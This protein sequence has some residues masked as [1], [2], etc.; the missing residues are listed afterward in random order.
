MDDADCTAFLQWA[1]PR[2]DLQWA[3][4]RRVREQVCKRLKRRIHLLGLS[5]FTAYQDL[6]NT[7]PD[8]WRT[9][10]DCCRITISRFFRD[11]RVFEILCDRILPGIAQRA[12][13][14]QRDAQCWSAGCASGEE[15]YTLRLLWDLKTGATARLSIVA[16]DVDDVVLA[17]ARK[18]C[19][20]VAALRELP[21]D[22]IARG[23]ED[24]DHSFRI[25]ERHRRDITFM[26]HDVRSA[27]IPGCFDL[28]LC[29][30]LA[31]T[32]FAP[33]LQSQVLERLA[34]R[35]RPNGWLVIGAHERLP[36]AAA[37]RLT[38]LAGA[39]HILQRI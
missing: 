5:G 1:L 23:F 11:G 12:R 3:G 2:L 15:P 14:Q 17:R 18:G 8:E 21:P 19:Y 20:P 31:F 6:L 30:N 34:E 39:P 29:R 26:H 38:P 22:L 16:T 33:R 13:N 32:Y 27:A 9:V 7:N 10:D 36:D 4:F 37:P 35:L 24:T 28:I 25:L